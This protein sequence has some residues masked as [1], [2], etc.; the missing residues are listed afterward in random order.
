MKKWM[1]L[2]FNILLILMMILTFVSCDARKIEEIQKVKEAPLETFFLSSI[3][4]IHILDQGVDQAKIEE[5]IHQRLQ[6]I[7][8]KMSLNSTTSEIA[9]LNQAAGIKAVK[10]SQ[11]SFQVIEESIQ[12]SEL[13]SGLF[14]VSVGGLVQLWDIGG[15]G[16]R[17]P[18]EQEIQEVLPLVDFKEMQLDKD[19]RTVYLK[20]KGMAVD[21]GAIAKGYA[22]DVIVEILQK[23]GVQNAI[24]NLG[25]NVYVHGSK[26]GKPFNVGIRDP[27]GSTNDYIGIYKAADQSIVT[28]GIYERYF[29]QDDRHYH[30]ILSTKTGY[31]IDNGLVSVSIVTRRSLDADALSTSIFAMGISEGLKLIDSLEDTEAVLID[32]RNR[33]YLSQGAKEQ[34]HLTDEKFEI[35]N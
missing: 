33:V 27:K 20:H 11:D 31:P 4:Q 3:L 21:L 35:S 23:E 7:E 16:Q 19:Q 17:L 34:F 10:L 30:H 24:V 12:Y 6:D 25:G 5:K 2:S 28:S 32:E 1:K 14:D 22:A 26:N 13:S 8:E 29:V 18:S 15:E 9:R